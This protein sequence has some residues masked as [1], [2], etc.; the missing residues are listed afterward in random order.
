MLDSLIAEMRIVKVGTD[1]PFI[2]MRRAAPVVDASGAICGFVP[3][4]SW[5][6]IQQVT[7]EGVSDYRE[8]M[9]YDDLAASGGIVDAP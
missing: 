3:C 4:G 5:E 7:F 9:S 8:A 1:K 2:E 6:P